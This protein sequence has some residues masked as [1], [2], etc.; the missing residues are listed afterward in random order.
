M[1]DTQEFEN[2]VL[3]KRH[4]SPALMELLLQEAADRFNPSRRTNRD[5]PSLY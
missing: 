1:A 2:F 5:S 3:E 4:I